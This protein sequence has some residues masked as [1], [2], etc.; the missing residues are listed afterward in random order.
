[1]KR[2]KKEIDIWSSVSS[3]DRY[4]D[5]RTARPI[6]MSSNHGLEEGFD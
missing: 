6:G 3:R 2:V 1:M 5:W 4:E